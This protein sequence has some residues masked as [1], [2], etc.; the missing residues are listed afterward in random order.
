MSWN[1]FKQFQEYQIFCSA[2]GGGY[3]GQKGMGKGKA[4]RRA[5]AYGGQEEGEVWGGKGTNKIHQ[6]NPNPELLASV[7]D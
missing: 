6:T 4:E 3:G 7:A 5:L 1:Q 2:Y